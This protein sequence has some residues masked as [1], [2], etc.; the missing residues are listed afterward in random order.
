ML[1]PKQLEKA[2]KKVEDENWM[3]R[4]FLK[5]EDSDHLDSRVHD[6]H[7]EL[8]KHMDCISCANC[9]KRIVPAFTRKDINRIAKHLNMTGADF[10]VK[11]IKEKQGVLVIKTKPC[12]FL[13]GQGCSI[14]AVR[15]E[16]C[17]GFPYTDKKEM[18]FRLINLVENCRVCPVVFEIFERLK[19][20]YRTEFEE[21]KKEMAFY[22]K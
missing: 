9:C 6:L 11:Y 22:W 18:V 1:E 21:Y 20:I 2:F 17:R 7:R 19:G 8:F 16:C 4:S 3:F 13:T 15:P 10:K 12:P 14:Y 5:G